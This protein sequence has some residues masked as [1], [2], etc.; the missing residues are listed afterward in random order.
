MHCGPRRGRSKGGTSRLPRGRPPRTVGSALPRGRARPSRPR[1]RNARC[2]AACPPRRERR[3]R[4]ARRERARIRRQEPV[5]AART[6][7]KTREVDAR[8]IDR[9]PLARLCHLID[10]PEEEF[11]HRRGFARKAVQQRPRFRRR[12]QREQVAGMLLL[13][14]GTR[15]LFENR[16][17]PELLRKVG[18][19]FP[20]AGQEHHERDRARL[21]PLGRMEQ[22]RHLP[23]EPHAVLRRKRL[24]MD[25]FSRRQPIRRH[26]PLQRLRG[27]VWGEGGGGLQS[28]TSE[29][30]NGEFH[31]G[32]SISPSV[33]N[34]TD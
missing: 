6:V 10:R 33:F 15:D 2:G 26:R 21:R 13:E 25:V 12:R 30:D 28:A 23:R 18:A 14:F 31:P 19:L 22:E 24:R 27:G 17:L 3:D 32:P 29:K 5:N 20:A 1:C 4:D 9:R 34:R 8:G 16:P 11:L 7:G